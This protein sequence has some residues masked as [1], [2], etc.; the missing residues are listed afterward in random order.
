MRCSIVRNS[1]FVF[2]KF[3]GN[4]LRRWDFCPIFSRIAGGNCKEKSRQKCVKK[5]KQG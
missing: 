1:G 4:W 3:A 5:R 2:W